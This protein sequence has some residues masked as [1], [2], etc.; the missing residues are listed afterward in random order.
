M[1]GKP[2]RSNA[3]VSLILLGFCVYI[4]QLFVQKDINLYI[5]PRYSIFAAV[6]CSLAVVILVAGILFDLQ[7]RSVANSSPYKVQF[8][9]VIV[10]IVLVLA[11]ILPSQALSS[12]AI[13]RKSLNTP[14][15]ETKPKSTSVS[16]TCPETK[17]SSIE[18]WVYEISQYPINCYKGQSIELT[19]FVFEAP[20]SPL[21][22]DMY[23]LGRMVMSCCVIDARPYALPIKTGSF[24]KYPNETWLKVSGKLQP[25]D[26][27]GSIQLVL[28]PDSVDKVNNPDKPYDYIN[29]P[30]RSNVQPLE[31]IQ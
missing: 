13:G 30:S 14:S 11:F 23:Y 18:A 26:V 4:I 10:V 29:T 28:E 25:A 16:D 22:N 2:I 1:F 8:L 21:P 19:G 27:N 31:P 7:K 12:K 20:E 6:M 3:V 17:P 24:E 5:H 15:Y 9:D